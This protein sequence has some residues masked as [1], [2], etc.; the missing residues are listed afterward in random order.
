[1][2]WHTSRDI[3]TFR[4]NI[5][6]MDIGTD[7]ADVYLTDIEVVWAYPYYGYTPEKLPWCKCIF[8]SAKLRDMYIN[9]SKKQ[10]QR[11]FGI[12]VIMEETDI[13][14]ILRALINKEIRNCSTVKVYSDTQLA[15]LRKIENYAK[16]LE[17]MED[18]LVY[19][20]KYESLPSI[21]F[22]RC[23][24]EFVSEGCQYSMYKDGTI[25]SFNRRLVGYVDSNRKIQ[26]ISI[27]YK[28]LERTLLSDKHNLRDLES[29]GKYISRGLVKEVIRLEHYSISDTTRERD[30]DSLNVLIKAPTLE[31]LA[32]LREKIDNKKRKLE[33]EPNLIGDVKCNLSNVYPSDTFVKS[34]ISV[35][36]FDCE[37]YSPNG[38]FPNKND[39]D[40][41][42]R[43]LGITYKV[44]GDDSSLRKICINIGL[45]DPIEDIEIFHVNTEKE[46]FEI[47]SRIIRELNPLIITGYNIFGFDIPYMQY[48][49]DTQGI[50]LRDLG[51]TKGYNDFIYI[52]GPRG[53]QYTSLAIPGRMIFDM[54]IYFRDRMT[55]KLN[56]YSLNGV[57]EYYKVGSK[58]QDMPYK[59]MNNIFR[60]SDKGISSTKAKMSK[61]IEYCVH[62]S[63]LCIM[64][65]ERHNVYNMNE[66]FSNLIGLNPDRIITSGQMAKGTA[67]LMRYANNEVVLNRR[68]NSPIEYDGGYVVCKLKGLVKNVACGDFKSL[69]P[70]IIAGNNLCPTTLIPQNMDNPDD[71]KIETAYKIVSKKS[72]LDDAMDEDIFDEHSDSDDE[73]TLLTEEKL[74]K[75]IIDI[76]EVDYTF[77]FAN[78]N[79]RI[80]LLPKVCKDLMDQRN[81]AKKELFKV[82]AR[83]K[84][85]G[86]D[87]EALAI[88][89]ECLQYALKITNN[90]LYGAMGNQFP[91]SRS[92]VE[93]AASVTAIGR[94]TIKDVIKF[95]TTRGMQVCYGD[96]DSCMFSHTSAIERLYTGRNTTDYN[97]LRDEHYKIINELNPGGQ[98]NHLVS[99]GLEMECEK[100]IVAGIFLRK[101]MYVLWVYKGRDENGRLLTE[102][103]PKGIPI[104]RR[105]TCGA[106]KRYYKDMLIAIYEENSPSDILGIIHRLLMD[107]ET[108]VFEDYVTTVRYRGNY[109]G[110]APMEVLAQKM[111]RMDLPIDSGD[112]ISYVIATGDSKVGVS[113]RYV[114]KEMLEK[115]D[116]IEID[117]CYYL[118]N[119][120]LKRLSDLWQTC[121]PEMEQI[122][123][124]STNML[125]VIDNVILLLKAGKSFRSIRKYIS[126][127][128]DLIK[129][130][131]AE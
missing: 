81:I 123:L 76:K 46:M 9:R 35:L 24:M 80:G 41:P 8:K 73:D 13:D 101:K 4:R 53:T 19:R 39:I 60:D 122:E 100:F 52:S 78:S 77:R 43:T 117:V 99:R 59:E 90:S 47:F 50:H 21:N 74:K 12:D 119:R 114:T 32:N 17:K 120:I 79:R 31:E 15:I 94:R 16:K 103:I 61:V 71:T 28:H 113:E 131:S 5:L 51:R 107:A 23:D 84:A 112:R 82:N 85:E 44:I 72:V 75:E 56:D 126:E 64:L 108:P 26:I 11:A 3:S 54:Y 38:G 121:F 63:L 104:T 36:S 98:Y 93:V 67:L 40:C 34:S 49:C 105:D 7:T 96:T 102:M 70:S 25:Y 130:S 6:N 29:S 97:A 33:S 115:L 91:H 129:C 66:A 92:C 116:D 18:S 68:L 83:M 37:M 86:I 125:D 95:M 45:A 128:I 110:K 69:Y 20:E 42:I 62:D 22:D 10:L 127:C 111:R 118:T 48:R 87:L 1:M 109:I 89:Y 55:D 124:G 14:P 57:C 27:R 30:L 2:N 58:K 65:M 106:L 88:Y